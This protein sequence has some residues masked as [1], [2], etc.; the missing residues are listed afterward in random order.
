VSEEDT[1][2]GTGC[3][4][5]RRL[6]GEVG[7]A[8]AIEH[9]QVLIGGSDTVESDIGVGFTNRLAGKTVQQIHGS[10]EPIYP[11]ANWERSLKWSRVTHNV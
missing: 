2:S 8:G 10:L 1:S 4:F 6:S 7:I 3:Q 5:M 9:P 11:I